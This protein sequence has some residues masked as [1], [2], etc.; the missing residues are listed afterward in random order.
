MR[1]EL[2]K[3]VELIF[4]LDAS[5]VVDKEEARILY[6]QSRFWLF[7]HFQQKAEAG[8]TGK[9]EA[10][11]GLGVEL[12]CVLISSIRIV[13]HRLCGRH[14]VLVIEHLRYRGYEWNYGDPYFGVTERELAK[15]GVIVVSIGLN[16]GSF[17]NRV[18]RGRNVI[19]VPRLIINLARYVLG[20]L[21]Q[22][23][24]RMDL[25][26]QVAGHLDEWGLS[27]LI[28]RAD[29][30]KRL[31]QIRADNFFLGFVVRF[32][33]PKA[34][35]CADA[36]NSNSSFILNANKRGVP[37]VEYQHGIISEG[38]V[39]YNFAP[40]YVFPDDVMPKHY[41]LWGAF[42]ANSLGDSLMRRADVR[43]GTYEYGNW[44]RT[45]AKQQN[46]PQG[47]LFIMQPSAAAF[48]EDQVTQFKVQY[49]E[50]RVGVRYHPRQKELLA[51]GQDIEH[52]FH[53]SIYN[54]F[55]DY[56][57]IVGCFSTALFEAVAMQRH[58]FFMP[59]PGF[60]AYE[61]IL[62]S[63]GIKPLS[64]FDELL[65]STAEESKGKEII[66]DFSNVNV[67]RDLLVKCR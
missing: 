33:G 7:R 37:T 27:C 45:H 18:Y 32:I 16:S 28:S 50:V 61:A 29:Y 1:V 65:E 40:D 59:V 63:A 14:P 15:E 23:E 38:H 19:V 2:N 47:V 42:W 44:W 36:Y 30:A 5:V 62:K 46:Q 11:R 8:G 56:Q 58:V 55:L 31:L 34:V 52:H 67:L 64:G 41:A 48:I 6:H 3:L 25:V 43:V 4:R 9:G 26:D 24:A 21:G 20:K 51:A 57:C 12:L 60:T 22:S 53:E 13:W 10:I 49:P 17:L 54:L 66:S 39:G 35:L